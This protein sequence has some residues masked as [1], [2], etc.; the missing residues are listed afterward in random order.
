M[1]ARTKSREKNSSR[2]QVKE[3]KAQKQSSFKYGSQQLE[4]E[5]NLP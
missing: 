5:V 3:Q 4:L 2:T 1:E